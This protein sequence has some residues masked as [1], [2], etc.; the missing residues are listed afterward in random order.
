MDN[1]AGS[2]GSENTDQV[3]YVAGFLL[4]ADDR[5]VV[6][7]KNRPAWQAGKRNGVG[8]KVEPGETPDVAMRREFR[9][10]TGLD[11]AEWEAFLTLRF[12]DGQVHFFR[13][14]APAKVLAAARTIT[15]EPI[16]CWHMAELL[17]PGTPI[18]PNLSWILPLAAYRHDRYAPLDAVEID[19]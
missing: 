1:V 4:D 6:V 2:V 12:A 15:D 11:I 8:G 7:R 16:E 14:F 9:E 17:R 19:I 13:S 3:V 5:V 10:E 18:I